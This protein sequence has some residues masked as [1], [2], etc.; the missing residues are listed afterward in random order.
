MH[1]K[2]CR[3]SVSLSGDSLEKSAICQ[4]HL[5]GPTDGAELDSSAIIQLRGWAAAPLGTD[6]Y[7][8]LRANQGTR[9]YPLADHRQDVTVHFSNADPPLEI[10]LHC[11]FLHDLQVA[12][13]F[14]GVRLGLE[15]RGIIT[16]VAT[17][18]AAMCDSE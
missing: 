9:S 16:W 14:A 15:T 12:E 4:W 1:T 10:P 13:L 2:R 6:V 8:V 7:F 18:T 11:G 5:E 3:I 17:V